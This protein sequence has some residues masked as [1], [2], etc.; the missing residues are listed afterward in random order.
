VQPTGISLEVVLENGVPLL[1]HREGYAR[2]CPCGLV[3]SRVT[4]RKGVATVYLR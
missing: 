4:V 3:Q 2:V 1:T